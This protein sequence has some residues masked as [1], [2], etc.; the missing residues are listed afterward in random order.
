MTA[1]N[2][3]HAGSAGTLHANSASEIPARL[4]ALGALGGLDRHAVHSQAI[5]ALQVAL[6]L[7]RRPDGR[8]ILREIAVFRGKSGLARVA[9]AWRYDDGPVEGW[10]DL[11]ALLNGAASRDRR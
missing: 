4:E 9:P 8:R 2:T 10:G 3:G 7:A 1:L 11:D 5:A 6:H